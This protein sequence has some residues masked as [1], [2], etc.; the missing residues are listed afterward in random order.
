[1]LVGG[2]PG[3]QTDFECELLH[4]FNEF[5]VFPK[6]GIPC[7]RSIFKVRSNERDIQFEHCVAGVLVKTSVK[8][9]KKFPCFVADVN[10]VG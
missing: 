1:M 8:Q 3:L 7:S 9:A 4:V 6:E 10:N 5:Y 2:V